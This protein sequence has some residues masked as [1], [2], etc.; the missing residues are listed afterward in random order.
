MAFNLIDEVKNYITPDIISKASSMLGESTGGIQK[1]IEGSLPVLVGGLINKSSQSDGMSSIM[2]MFSGGN[3]DSGILQNVSG[4]FS[5]GG[6]SSSIMS[7]GS[8]LLS[9][10][11]GD[12]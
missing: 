6:Q 11:F 9:G 8:S 10:L 2:N 1:A 7:A 5:S 3:F 12:K 4:L